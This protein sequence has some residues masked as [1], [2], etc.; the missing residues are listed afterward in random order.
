MRSNNEQLLC[1]EI[2]PPPS[3]NNYLKS[4]VLNC[5]FSNS[6]EIRLSGTKGGFTPF[7]LSAQGLRLLCDNLVIWNIHHLGYYHVQTFIVTCKAHLSM[8][9]DLLCPAD[10][11]LQRH[12]TEEKHDMKQLQKATLFTKK[13][14]PFGTSIEGG[15]VIKWIQ[16]FDNV[17]TGTSL[18]Q[19]AALYQSRPLVH[20]AHYRLPWLAAKDSLSSTWR[21]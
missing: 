3:P 6:N 19:E 13:V 10:K 21:W 17:G 2:F 15:M 12:R 1:S 7:M 4:S 8:G 11:P 16:S 18:Q 14:F 20:L 9:R 5:L